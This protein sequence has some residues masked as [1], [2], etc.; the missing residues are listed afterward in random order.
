MKNE[1][2]K[3]L[4]SKA[5][6][7]ID[8][9]YIEEA[10]R[11][12][13]SVER[14]SVA[15]PWRRRL[16]PIACAC[17]IIVVGIF[18]IPHP[19][20]NDSTNQTTTG[21]EEIIQ[22]IEDQSW[23]NASYL[24][25]FQGI[26]SSMN[27]A[28]SP[29]QIAVEKIADGIYASY[30]AG[31]T[32]DASYVGEFLERVTVKSYW[33]YI[34]QK[35]EKD[36]VYVSADI[37]SINGVSPSAAVCVRYLEKGVANT[38]E[39]YYIFNHPTW[40][41]TSLEEFYADFNLSMHLSDRIAQACLFTRA[42]DGQEH[43]ARLSLSDSDIIVLRALLLSLTGDRKT[44]MNANEMDFYIADSH[45]QGQLFLTAYTVAHPLFVVQIFDHGY[46]MVVRE[47]EMMLF[48]I[49]EE[50]AKQILQLLKQA[51]ILPTNNIDDSINEIYEE[52]SRDNA[53]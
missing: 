52:T 13:T 17:L 22:N 43:R 51:S 20:S 49:G 48:E 32:I 12:I 18:F 9:R 36:T 35:L 34:P 15:F 40:A 42:E 21:N 53:T 11:E 30:E 47:G 19:I 37:Y 6:S 50:N 1:A 46:L 23:R 25:G 2:K 16:L 26:G 28:T 31:Y 8:L 24:M 45:E 7:A 5:L 41:G 44:V 33:Y 27:E 4:L 10:E 39:H 3:H 38:T 14:N 29:I